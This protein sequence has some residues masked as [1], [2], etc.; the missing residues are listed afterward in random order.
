LV[1]SSRG[2]IYAS[3]G[4]D[5]AEVAAAEAEKLQ[6]QMEAELVKIGL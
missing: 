6:K 3:N 5:F 4:E 1:N 2:I